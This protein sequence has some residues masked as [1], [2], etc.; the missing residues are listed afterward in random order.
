[1]KILEFAGVVFIA[2]NI[3]TIQK[4]NMAKEDSDEVVP[5]LQIVT[6]AGG[7]NF[8]FPKAEERDAK[9][10]ELKNQLKEL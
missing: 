9:F 7:V 2:E 8:T 10:T 6:V 3:C 4:V 5:G 1:M